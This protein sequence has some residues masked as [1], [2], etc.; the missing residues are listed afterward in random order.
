MSGDTSHQNYE[1][2]ETTS[3]LRAEEALTLI[4]LLF[5]YKKG[6]KSYFKREAWRNISQPAQNAERKNPLRLCW[7]G[8]D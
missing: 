6:W 5:I 8:S 1:L 2:K 3:L 4:H 7:K